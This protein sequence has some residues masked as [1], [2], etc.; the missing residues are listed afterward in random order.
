MMLHSVSPLIRTNQFDQELVERILD[1]AQLSS[2]LFTSGRFLDTQTRGKA[3][4][5][6]T[7]FSTRRPIVFH[8]DIEVGEK[9]QSGTL[10]LEMIGDASA[11]HCRNERASL[12][13]SRRAQ[14]A[15]SDRCSIFAVPALGLVARKSGL[16]RKLPGLRLLSD[17][18]ALINLCAKALGIGTSGLAATAVLRTHRLGK[19]A[20][21]QVD[22][23]GS[24]TQ[25]LFLRL[26]P[27]S[28]PSGYRAF[29]QYRALA[30]CFAPLP[31]ITVPE[32][33]HFDQNLGVAIYSDVGGAPMDFDP[34][35]QQCH[36]DAAIR[37][38]D[39]FARIR[40]QS[41][42][43]HTGA[44]ELAI[45]RGWSRH[46]LRQFPELAGGYCRALDRLAPQLM[47][48]GPF[49]PCHR[50]LHEGQLMVQPNSVGIVDFDTFKWGDPAMDTGNFI[51]HLRLRA[52]LTGMSLRN[53]ERQI[54]STALTSNPANRLRLWTDASLLRLAGIRAFTSGG[55]PV[56]NALLREVGR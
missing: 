29:R 18:G 47:A 45:I 40:P 25:R 31:G 43:T 15:K 37:A 42:D 22:V 56:A 12:A 24:V 48:D 16:D 36:T 34:S 53:C 8:A 51:A 44:D 26:R 54:A 50:D 5:S 13:K 27:V 33:L 11:A 10:L 39:A 9:G 19:R 30:A 3:T 41:G 52:I 32:A 49:V 20:V 55:L 21:L 28:S 38:I 2:A 4:I 23:T 1:P 46:L 35:S 17:R 7:L 6:R 14:I